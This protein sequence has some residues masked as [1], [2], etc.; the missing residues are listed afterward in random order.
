MAA[1]PVRAGADSCLRSRPVTSGLDG[2]HQRVDWFGR[3]PKPTTDDLFGPFD[4]AVVRRS[5]CIDVLH[6][7]DLGKTLAA[8]LA[9]WLAAR[10]HWL[11]DP[12]GRFNGTNA[13]VL[14]SCRRWARGKFGRGD[15][16]IGPTGIRK[17]HF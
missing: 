6:R 12:V 10:R 16:D 11:H 1:D 7:N 14:D 13:V 17:T 15:P 8:G 5:W 4:I 3:I 2:Q 9:V